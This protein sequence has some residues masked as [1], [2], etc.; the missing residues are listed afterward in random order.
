MRDD[1]ILL[2][3]VQ[4]IVAQENRADGEEEEESDGEP[5][6]SR[7]PSNPEGDSS[8]MESG[9]NATQGR[10]AAADKIKREHMQTPR[11]SEAG[12]A[13]TARVRSTQGEGTQV[14]PTTQAAPSATQQSMIV[15]L[16]GD[17]EDEEDEE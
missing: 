9:A 15:D 4:R 5:S 10:R 7:Q 8:I 2:R 6:G 1:P 14:I 3:K 17:D 12:T 13:T 16:E 11:L